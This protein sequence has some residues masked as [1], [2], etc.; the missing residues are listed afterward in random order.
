MDIL[1]F[2]YK[3]VKRALLKDSLLGPEGFQNG[4][5][6]GSNSDPSIPAHTQNNDNKTIVVIIPRQNETT[7]TKNSLNLHIS[8]LIL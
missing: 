2:M 4:F 7:K 3:T 5:E 1:N 6:P 8:H